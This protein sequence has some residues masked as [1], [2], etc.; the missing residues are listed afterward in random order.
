MLIT[1]KLLQTES[2]PRQ[3]WQSCCPTLI[4]W[5][6]SR[7]VCVFKVNKF[8][9]NVQVPLSILSLS[10]TGATLI[11]C[12]TRGRLVTIPDPRGK[13]SRPTRLSNTELFPLLCYGTQWKQFSSVS[14]RTAGFYQRANI[15]NAYWIS[16]H[17]K[18][19]NSYQKTWHQWISVT[20][21]R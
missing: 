18:N 7:L 4:R 17:I 13:K 12:N 2:M 16:D 20:S 14:S 10:W 1:H 19:L 6:I 21:Y 5:Y 15:N 9:I 11:S 3:K 8:W